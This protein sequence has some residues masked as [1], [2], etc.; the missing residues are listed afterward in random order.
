MYF[1]RVG[2]SIALFI[3]GEMKESDVDYLVKFEM[4]CSL[5]WQIV[6]HRLIQ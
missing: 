3:S 5:A 2:R 4:Y 6:R 1:L